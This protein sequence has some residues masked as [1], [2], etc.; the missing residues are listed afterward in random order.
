M[1]TPKEVN[2]TRIFNLGERFAYSPNMNTPA[3]PLVA[4][5]NGN[6]TVLVPINDANTQLNRL[7]ALS[8]YAWN[9]DPTHK[10]PDGTMKPYGGSMN[11]K[12]IK[13]LD[14]NNISLNELVNPA[15][16]V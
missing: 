7:P 14:R 13:C 3:I 6:N 12:N 8:K 1:P 4:M 2:F 15:S 5:S 11:M 9:L 10:N 16:S